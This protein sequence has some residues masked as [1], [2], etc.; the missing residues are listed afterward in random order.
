MG[1]VYNSARNSS[2]PTKPLHHLVT[3]ATLPVWLRELRRGTSSSANDRAHTGGELYNLHN[4]ASIR[5]YCA[6]PSLSSAISF[7]PGR[8][9]EGRVVSFPLDDVASLDSFY[10]ASL[11]IDSEFSPLPRL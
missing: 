3:V 2:L 9:K 5:E 6:H 4:D 7:R 8:I 1:P 10:L 11:T